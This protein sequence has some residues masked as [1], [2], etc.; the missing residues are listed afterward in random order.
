V[1][2]ISWQLGGILMGSPLP[3]GFTIDQPSTLTPGGALTPPSTEGLPAG[4]KLDPLPIP[5]LPAAPDM[6]WG[7]LGRAL[8]TMGVRGTTGLIDAVADPLAPIR[9]LISPSMERIEQQGSVHPGQML[10][11]AIMSA[12]GLQDFEP[13]S[14]MGRV[15][16][17]AGTG[18]AGGRV[19][20]PVGMVVGGVGGGLGQVA[21]EATSGWSPDNSERAETAAGLVPG[22]LASL[23]GRRAVSR[24]TPELDAAG[25]NPT[26]GQAM[27]GV[28]NRLEQGLGSIPILGDFIKS[29]RAGAVE[30][31]NRGAINQALGHI[32]E[33]LDPRTPLG[34]P[35]IDEAATRI[36]NRYDA[37]TPN[38]NVTMDPQ[39]ATALTGLNRQVSMLS[40]D[41]QNQFANTFQ[42][43]ILDR[44]QG[45]PNLTGQAFRDAEST[46][47][48]IARDNRSSPLPADRAFGNA[49]QD[50][51]TE[52]RGLLRRSNPNYAGELQNIHNAYRTMLPV[53]IAAARMGT[54]LGGNAEPGVFTP[55]QLTSGVRQADPTL[56]NRGFAR[57]NA[58]LQDYAEGGRA[59]LGDTLPDSGTPYRSIAAL[60]LGAAGGA[61]FLDPATL[62]LAAGGAAGGRLLYS[63][64]GRAAINYFLRR[65]EQA[66]AAGLLAPPRQ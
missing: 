65:P 57:G 4:F 54:G 49:V 32:N 50:L 23:A 66:A 30:D 27:G 2:K 7:D 29:G 18:A 60:G 1:G 37:I 52:L 5:Q 62:A 33:Q 55:S 45:G 12:T 56:R 61:P 20:G 34:R 58:V 3:P 17:A 43:E 13:T 51:Q 38:L 31:F 46:L 15:G 24:T 26:F 41:H 21:K 14:P 19:F 39:F 36:G 28:F 59:L 48:Q 22:L 42:T 10:G 9:R 47:G 16:M 40:R 63:P 64:Q 25:V 35:A 6:N 11:N 8:A 44:M 53:E